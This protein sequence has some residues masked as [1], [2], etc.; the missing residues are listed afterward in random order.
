MELKDIYIYRITHIEN[1]PHILNYGIT[2][3]DSHY[4]NTKYRNIGDMS[5]IDTR[6]KRVVTIDN[7][8]FEIKDSNKSIT[9]GN[10]TPFYFGVRMPMLYVAQQGGNFVEQPTKPAEIV[11]LSIS[12]QKLI[13][14][15]VDF[16][17]TDGHATDNLT[18]FYDKTKISELGN[19]IDWTAI[20]SRYWGGGE[21]LNAKRKKQAELL[22]SGD[23]EPKLIMG[24]GCYNE[25]AKKRLISMGVSQEKIKI[26]PQSY[27]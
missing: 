3:R 2:H 5:L 11:Y 12:L 27:Y 17:F 19:I 22:I 18:S 13:L 26:I 1:I 10:Y 23:L 4:R 9:L 7:G 8:Q 20:K 15:G 21:N 24:M 6:S 14:T 16:F 25:E